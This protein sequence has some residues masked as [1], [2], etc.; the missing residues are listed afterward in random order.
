MTCCVLGWTS[1]VSGCIEHCEM[2]SGG[3]RACSRVGC[4]SM[5]RLSAAVRRGGISNL[6]VAFSNGCDR[7]T[8]RCR[9]TA[10]GY[11]REE[12]WVGG[13]AP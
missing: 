5:R 2:T 8:A 11:A 6:A 10:F 9:L 12:A 4:G 13:C 3:V 7:W 1:R